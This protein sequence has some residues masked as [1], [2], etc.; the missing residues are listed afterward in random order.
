MRSETTHTLIHTHTQAGGIS[1]TLVPWQAER[2][3]YGS[4]VKV[5]WCSVPTAFFLFSFSLLFFSPVFSVCP[6]L[7]HCVWLASSL[8]IS[9]LI[10]RESKWVWQGCHVCSSKGQRGPAQRQEVSYPYISLCF[11]HQL[12][13]PSL[14]F[15]VTLY[16][17]S[18]FFC[19]LCLS[20]LPVLRFHCSTSQLFLSTDL[21]F[22]LSLSETTFTE[23]D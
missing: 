21:M 15:S 1:R 12:D 5:S 13:S 20:S 9:L 22:P 4:N 8:H 18:T 17:S 3:R 23:V 11:C 2:H 16:L 6:S 14:S 10:K 7:A 19:P